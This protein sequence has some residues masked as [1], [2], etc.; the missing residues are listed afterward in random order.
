[1]QTFIDRLKSLRESETS[2][3]GQRNEATTRLQV[4][5]VLLFEVLDWPRSAC[6]NEDHLD[7]TYTDYNLG[8]P[9]KQLVLEAKREGSYFEIPVTSGPLLVSLTS[10]CGHDPVL[11][12]AVEQV[13]GYCNVRGIRFA[14]IS[15]GHQMVTF[16][17][18]RTD[19]T[20]PTAG[21][22]LV[23]RSLKDM[24]ES[25]AVLWNSLSPE[26]VAEG[27]LDSLLAGPALPPPPPKLSRQLISYPG[28]TYRRDLDLELEILGEL[29]LYQL[30]REP[31][32]EVDFL[33]EC[34]CSSGALSQFSLLTRE[35]LKIRYLATEKQQ[36]VTAQDKG[37]SLRRS[38]MS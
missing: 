27:Y 10:L 28:S 23:F 14:A 17:G 36:E 35:L 37:G 19:G 16:I 5:D 2:S 11:R 13:V 24:E 6:T 34:Y 15:N 21:K 12:A 4:I 29:F 7:G 32:F 25:F 33:R 20:P 18:S 30:V 22:A 3:S 38:E 9:S 8:L 26:G 31:E 1:L